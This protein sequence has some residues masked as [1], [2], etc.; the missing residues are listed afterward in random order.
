M[1]CSTNVVQTFYK[2]GTT[3]DMRSPAVL[4]ESTLMQRVAAGDT[5]AFE[6]LYH[7]HGRGAFMLARKLGAPRELAEEVVQDA[8]LSLW[9]RAGSY[10]PERGSVSAWLGTI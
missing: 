5:T 4:P 8:F 3:T 7:R 1:A 2:R 10:R 6:Q 9:R